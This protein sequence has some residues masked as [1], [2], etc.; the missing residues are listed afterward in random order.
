MS[1]QDKKQTSDLTNFLKKKNGEIKDN[2]K[3]PPVKVNNQ[4]QRSKSKAKVNAIQQRNEDAEE[5]NDSISL[6]ID[7]I[8]DLETPKKTKPIK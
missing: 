3:K 6:M 4:S 2:S 8:S 5:E 1:P 7:K